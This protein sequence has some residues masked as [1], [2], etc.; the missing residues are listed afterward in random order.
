MNA[1]HFDLQLFTVELWPIGP[2]LAKPA[3]DAS[4]LLLFT[5]FKI[6][7]IFNLGRAM[8]VPHNE[9]LKRIAI[10]KHLTRIRLKRSLHPENPFCSS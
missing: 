6:A 10:L 5:E 8:R 2:A 3:L 9:S 7:E 4:W 1:Y